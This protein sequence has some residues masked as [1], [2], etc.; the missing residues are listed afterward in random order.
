[1]K[2]QIWIISVCVLLV[3][4]LLAA[5]YFLA[6]PKPEDGA[7]TPGSS[8]SSGSSEESSQ[9]D[10]DLPYIV[11]DAYPQISTKEFITQAPALPIPDADAGREE[12]IAFFY[13]LLKP[14]GSWYNLALTST[15]EQAKDMDLARLFFNGTAATGPVLTDAETAFLTGKLTMEL[16]KIKIPA[17]D[18]D[19]VLD[20]Y[21]GITYED[22]TNRQA[23]SLIYFDQT[24]CY[25]ANSTY[26]MEAPVL[27]I[28]DYTI[29]DDGIYRV[30]YACGYFTPEYFEVVLE[31]VDDHFRVVSNL[32]CTI[33]P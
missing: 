4:A 12:W 31:R 23:E 25:Y 3:I 22:S 2:K 24:D 15:Y 6:G 17:A 5:V 20:I 33:T 29:S 30:R 9:P 13:G 21:F 26:P 1:M 7:S 32:P 10:D 8:E 16:D 27:G 11:P 18:L 14:Y 19:S 28:V